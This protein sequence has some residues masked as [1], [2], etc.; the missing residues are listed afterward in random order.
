MRV[1][2]LGAGLQAQAACYD[3]VQQQDLEEITVADAD[4]QAAEALAA[5]WKDPRVKP[6]RLDAADYD[7]AVAVLRGAKAALSAVPY[8]FNET[9]AKAA[10]AAGCSFCDLGGNNTVVNAELALHAEAE[11]AGV[12]IVPDCGLAP[13]MVAVLAADAVNHL[14]RTDSLEIRVGGL[15]QERGSLL[16]YSLLFNIQGL[17]NEYVEDAVVLEG[18]QPKVVPSLED[19]E[20]VEFPAPFGTLEAFTTSGGTSTLPET[21]R[22][23]I[24]R[25]NYKTLRYPGHGKVFQALHKLGMLTWDEVEVDGVKVAPRAVFSKVAEPVLDLGLP[26]VA[27]VRLVASGE[28]GGKPVTRSYQ[29]ISIEHGLAAMMR[30]PRSRPR[31]CCSCSPG[32]I[33]EGRAAPGRCVDPAAFL[34]ELARRG[35]S[36]SRFAS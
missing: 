9:L 32:Q 14:D 6:V 31:S 8:R 20:D 18:G 25:L 13:G 28:R 17:I 11:A 36:P 30:A 26:D 10:V 29:L 22:G 7:A 4:L 27:L 15:P 3:L 16:D 23:Q 12:T 19:F 34:R 35:T 1:V 24:Q 5:R 21:Y 33:G 2:L